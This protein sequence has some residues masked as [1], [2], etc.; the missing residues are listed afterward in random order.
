MQKCKRVL[1]APLN[2][3]L[4]HA[5]R[6]M[7]VIRHLLEQ[8][9]EVLL[10]SDG[11][12]LK[13]LSE[14]FPGCRNFELPAYSPRY[15]ESNSLV[16]VIARQLPKF[17][18]AIRD[19]HEQLAGLIDKENIHAVISDNRY[20][21]WSDK[22]PSAL[23]IH[24]LNLLM[25]APVRWISPVVNALHRRLMRR[26]KFIWVPD[27]EDSALTGKL[28][29]T[30]QIENVRFIGPLS[31]LMPPVDF[32]YRYD[33]VAVLSGPEPQR[34]LLEQILR[35]QLPE[36]GLAWR[37]VR[38]VV[39]DNSTEDGQAAIL[40]YLPAYKL[41]K[42]INETAVV[43]A[44]SGYSTIMDLYKLGK[45]AILIPTPGQP[46]QEYLAT[47]AMEK[48]YAVSMHQHVLSVKSAFAQAK[49]IS[50]FPAGE[51]ATSRLPAVVEELLQ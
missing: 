51:F 15:T 40:D 21:A 45:K 13:L 50:G 35:E 17:R 27:T 25:P 47:Q 18:S 19:E 39:K 29:A 20:G 38:G 44:R 24:Q 49:N 8:G 42:L 48:G 33:L 46:E 11:E 30:P 14:E 12:A 22:I 6:C 41:N 9:H 4:G 34:S 1:V 10:A 36:S 23:I 37:L 16:P 3:G 31:R 43:L 26:F 7:P 32:S 2:W 28:S 5:T